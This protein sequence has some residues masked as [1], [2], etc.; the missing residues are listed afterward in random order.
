MNVTRYAWAIDAATSHAL[1]ISAAFYRDLF[2]NGTAAGMVMFE[3]DFLS[4][5]NSKTSLTNTDVTTGERWLRAIGT[6]VSVC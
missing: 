6:A 1:P 5:I 3:Q 2:A 4:F